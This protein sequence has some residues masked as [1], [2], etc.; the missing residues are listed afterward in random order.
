MP[1]PDN[2]HTDH[3]AS[4]FQHLFDIVRRLRA[5]DGCSWDREQNLVS[6]RDALIEESYE[7]VDA[8]NE[9]DSDHIREELGDVFLLATM[10]SYIQEQAGVFTVDD[11]LDEISEKLVR[12]H[13]HVFGDSEASTSTEVIEQWNAIKK[14]E[15]PV[16]AENAGILD[17]IPGAFPPLRLAWEYQKKAAKVG[18]DWPDRKQIFEKLEEEIGEL[19]E[20]IAAARENGTSGSQNAN[21]PNSGLRD[22]ATT[23]ST[24]SGP[25][26]CI[27]DELGD[28]LFTVVNLA[29]SLGVVP[30]IALQ[31]TN[32]KFKKRFT[33]VEREM[34]DAGEKMSPENLSLMDTFWESS[35]I[36]GES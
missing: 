25:E 5:P 16:T 19:Q 15:K 4:S 28:V 21:S 10:M 20:A 17:K 14:T 24:T 18:F 36:V 35:K 11:V 30:D 27:E 12:R 29:R 6:L 3:T 34:R 22:S 2:T 8:I 1:L 7:C 31:R 13:P 32:A 23:D 9:G 26:S 33:A